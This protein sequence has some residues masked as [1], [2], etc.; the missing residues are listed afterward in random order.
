MSFQLLKEEEE[1]VR[2][3]KRH[4]HR[5]PEK[6]WHEYETTKYITGILER[7]PGI[8]ILSLG[9]TTGVVACLKGEKPGKCVA[10]RA[11]IDALE[12]V[13]CWES[14]DKSQNEGRGHLCGHDFHTASLLG[15][16]MILSRHR[17]ELEGNVIF[18]FQ[19]AEE[20]TNG[21]RVIIQTGIF[22]KYG[23]E[24]IFG[25]HNRPEVETGSVVV[26]TGSLMA[27][28]INFRIV[29]HGVGGHGSMPHK[30]VDPLVASAAII[31]N[32]LTIP[33]R[34]VDPMKSL[35]L[36][37][38]SIHGGTPD[39]LIVSE[40]EMTG[41]MRYHEPEVGR[42]A[43]ERLK[44][45]VRS[46]CETF[47]CTSEFEIVESVPAVINSEALYGMALDAVREA[48]GPDAAVTSESALATEDFADYMQLVPG[49]F[50]WL[51]SRRQ[52]DDV[53]SWHNS[54][55]HTDDN[56]IRYG[57]QLLAISARR[58]LENSHHASTHVEEC[59][60]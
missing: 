31:Q 57:S 22:E 10:L 38:C 24:A 17:A 51:G 5:H 44:T 29:V 2:G 25:L 42:R 43:L 50:Y 27:A 3:I 53:F 58:Y 28:K 7:I 52:G 32:V 30:C 49:F 59:T 1:V 16:A 19:P 37:I 54:K 33:A 20:T 56:A 34:N 48:I 11:D 47:E 6:S 55:F 23:I 13:E 4:L 15:A 12:V 40:V 35:V 8:E 41:S 21:A 9:L 26:K 46:T 60:P 45:V 36:S 18:I 14:A 39:N